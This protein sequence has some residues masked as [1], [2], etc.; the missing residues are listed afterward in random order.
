[1]SEYI[2]L[3]VPFFSQRENIYT[4]YERYDKDEYD[5]N[6]VLIHKKGSIKY[7]S[8]GI[9]MACQSCNI[10]SLCMILQ[11]LGIS[12]DSP[13]D[14]MKKIYEKDFKSW[15]TDPKKRR[16]IERSENLKEVL[17]KTYS[18]KEEKIKLYSDNN[19]LRYSDIKN[20]LKQGFPIW[21]SW[22]IISGG[23]SGHISVIR[24]ITETGDII[25]NDPWGDP[26]DAYGDVKSSGKKYYTTSEVKSDIDLMGF[27][28]G[29]NLVIKKA[30]FMKVLK[31]DFVPGLPK[32]DENRYC[33][34]ALVITEK[35]IWSDPLRKL[36]RNADLSDEDILK[37]VKIN[38][39]F[40]S[41]NKKGQYV[42]AGFPICQNGLWHNGI[43][44]SGP[45]GTPVYSIGPGRIVAVRNTED[46]KT[47]FVLV[48]YLDFNTQK[49]FFGLYKN[50][51]YIDIR[52]RIKEKYSFSLGINKVIQKE[53]SDWLDQII[54]HIMPKK[55]LVYI[56][57]NPEGAS[58]KDSLS[59]S[60]Y[61]KDFNKT[62]ITLKD[63]ALVFLCPKDEG[64]K[65]LLEDFDN[66]KRNL[67]SI[68]SFIT[69][70]STYTF[71]HNNQ[72]FY[73]IF[74]K[75]K[76]DAE[77]EWIEGYVKTAKV[78]PQ[79]FNF[80][81]YIYYRKKINDLLNGETVIFND[82]D[83][84]YKIPRNEKK[85]Y[86]EV[87]VEEIKKNFEYALARQDL[88]KET[89]HLNLI[90]GIGTYYLEYI[91]DMKKKREQRHFPNI[92]NSFEKK[93][94]NCC[95]VV[96]NY[97]SHLIDDPF[98]SGDKWLV[99]GE[100]SFEKN[101]KKICSEAF[102]EKESNERW[103][104]LYTTIRECV[105]KNVDYY[106]ECNNIVPL[107]K[108]G[109]T[110]DKT[111]LHVEFFSE[112]QIIKNKEYTVLEEK[113]FDNFENKTKTL[114]QLKDNFDFDKMF[115]SQEDF[116]KFYREN[117]PKLLKTI[118]NIVN[119]NI[120]LDGEKKLKAEKHKGYTITEIDNSAFIDK[121]NSKSIGFSKNVSY[122]YHP[123]ELIKYLNE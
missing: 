117:R 113:K 87:L 97:N 16:S 109:L 15:S 104:L 48:K 74:A 79:E 58:G 32:E 25:V 112:E 50:L 43:H 86:Q 8:N 65:Q 60:V 100:S 123:I 101:Y 72:K 121:H 91:N 82:E 29:D 49:T 9:S 3:A 67:D 42:Y 61:D 24:G 98:T 73:K 21:F 85:K 23:T 95:N 69:Q 7:I 4:W 6:K 114:D 94:F 77:Y 20:Y 37:Y 13:D 83:F 71:T 30:D 66:T 46:V 33:F 105:R 119:L 27:G 10:T 51:Q 56:E 108:I 63:R 22:G 1:M 116:L 52:N 106:L 17:K 81:E 75:K 26:T 89:N 19:K 34:Q 64:K 62:D 18:V 59:V 93:I 5:K 122:F 41:T 14:T 110:E 99:K 68:K 54:K 39:S 84:D 38:E 107:G 70:D 12:Y 28:Q 36:K 78:Y 55:A 120:K 88:L 76:A 102:S 35:R 53:A 92:I 44:L 2:N 96:F 47:N 118:A 90:N 57:N 11:Y 103:L 45:E 115:I 111:Y 40:I 80:Q 31:E